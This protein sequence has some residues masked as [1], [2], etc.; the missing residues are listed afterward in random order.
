VLVPLSS[1]DVPFVFN[2]VSADFQSLTIQGQL[3]YRVADAPRLSQLLDFSVHPNGRYVSEDPR[4]LGERLIALTQV[5]ASTVAHKLSL[6]QALVAYDTLSADCLKGLKESPSVQALGVEIMDLAVNS[7]KPSPETAKALET[8]TREALLREA[9]EAVYAR[10]NSAVEL[11]RKIKESELNTE[12]LVQEK[13]RQIREAKIAGDIAME[14]R[15]GVLLEQKVLNERK[16]AD[17]KAYA[18]NAVLTPIKG[19]DWRTLMSVSAG[20]MDAKMNIAMAFRDLA[21]NAGKIGELNIT[22][23]LLNTLLKPDGDGKR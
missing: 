3:T 17:S 6:R 10:R 20:K 16:E 4:K 15:R 7:L 21:E 19:M 23:D 8:E 5:L 18:L 9:D 12:M 1:V 14:E 11:E 13:N 22:P 2:E